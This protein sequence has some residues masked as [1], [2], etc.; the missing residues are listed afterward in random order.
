MDQDFLTR[1]EAEISSNYDEQV[2]KFISDITGM[3]GANRPE[4]AA[5]RFS[6]ALE[7]L[8]LMEVKGGEV[9]LEKRASFAKGEISLDELDAGEKFMS[10]MT[11]KS[12]ESIQK[13]VPL[14][15]AI[16]EA[17]KA[18]KA[19]AAPEQL[20][21]SEVRQLESVIEEKKELEDGSVAERESLMK[22]ANDF[23]EAAKRL[24]VAR[25]NFD[26]EITEVKDALADPEDPIKRITEFFT[27][28]IEKSTGRAVREIKWGL[29]LGDI[30]GAT[31]TLCATRVR[32]DAMEKE[33]FKVMEEAIS[34]GDAEKAS[35]AHAEKLI[36]NVARCIWDSRAMLDIYDSIIVK[37]VDKETAPDEL[38]I[39]EASAM[40][41][42]VRENAEL[43]LKLMAADRE[44]VLMKENDEL[45][46][47]LAKI[48][49]MTDS[50]RKQID[51]LKQDMA[52]N[53][54]LVASML[55]VSGF[56]SLE[57]FL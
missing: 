1:A 20:T 10:F 3:L 55:E 57:I 9:V 13:L 29:S 6:S 34:G 48:S 25:K 38:I 36:P 16:A 50:T 28:A 30:E 41:A 7:G 40:V 2:N 35:L 18:K 54:L 14:D 19:A 27:N 37:I 5:R 39:L 24:T 46:Q 31:K 23:K 11:K 53:S 42:L 26:V 45:K 32:L 17:L 49:L 47:E 22:N 43:K 8:S 15:R 52:R 44:V 12:V 51:E 4:E 56:C 21:P 33:I